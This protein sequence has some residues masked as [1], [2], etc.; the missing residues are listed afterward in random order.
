MSPPLSLGVPQSSWR[1]CLKHSISSL[2]S[3][4]LRHR[5]FWNAV[6]A[7]TFRRGFTGWQW[8][9]PAQWRI[10]LCPTLFSCPAKHSGSWKICLQFLVPRTELHL[11]IN[12]NLP[13]LWSSHTLNFLGM[14]LPCKSSKAHTAFY[15][16]FGQEL[17]SCLENHTSN[18]SWPSP[19]STGPQ[20]TWKVL[21]QFVT[22]QFNYSEHVPIK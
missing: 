16:E 12:V 13:F 5:E 21:D 2:R 3:Q 15:L 22:L 18:L 17:L 10:S 19:R 14:Q 1:I 9:S 7:A 8:N 20:C 11:H 6:A 4:E